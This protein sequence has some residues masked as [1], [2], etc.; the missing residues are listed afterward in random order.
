MANFDKLLIL[1]KIFSK[2]MEYS[3]NFMKFHDF[4]IKCFKNDVWSSKN[5]FWPSKCETT[6]PN[7]PQTSGWTIKYPQNEAAD[8]FLKNN[9]FH[10][11]PKISFFIFCI[12]IIYM[13]I[14]MEEFLKMMTSSTSNGSKNFSKCI[15][16]M[17]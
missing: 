4:S 16:N 1:K 14:E 11:F 8:D 12:F 7:Y 5:T 13:G 15:G 10:F 6:H 2:N 9:F 3:P 17:L